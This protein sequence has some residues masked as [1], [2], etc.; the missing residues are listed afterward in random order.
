MRTIVMGLM[1]LLLASDSMAVD[2]EDQ[3]AEAAL[4][5]A[6]DNESFLWY[7]ARRKRRM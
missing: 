4:A 7:L 6:Q 5:E 2:I 3:A 1:A